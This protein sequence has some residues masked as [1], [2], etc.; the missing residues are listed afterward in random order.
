MKKILGK[1]GMASCLNWQMKNCQDL[2]DISKDRDDRGLCGKQGT[3]DR[4]HVKKN[5][6]NYVKNDAY[7]MTLFH[8]KALGL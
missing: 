7:R 2:K 5:C 8:K 1:C 3:I 4:K 6:L